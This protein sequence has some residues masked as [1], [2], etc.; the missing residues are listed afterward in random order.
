M[1]TK[2]LY[3]ISN[4]YVQKRYLENLKLKIEI[5]IKI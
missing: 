2:L 1:S 3:C 4:I 5:E